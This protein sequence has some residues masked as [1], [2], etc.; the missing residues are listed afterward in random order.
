MVP[1]E[2]TY[3]RERA[4]VE[5]HRALTATDPRA[6]ELHAELASLYE[7]LVESNQHPKPKLHAMAAATAPVKGERNAAA[8]ASI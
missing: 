6:A 4:I 1:D 3:Y 7:T 2:L 8:E 5:R